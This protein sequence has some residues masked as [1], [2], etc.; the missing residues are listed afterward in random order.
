V[1]GGGRTG[2]PAAAGAHPERWYWSVVAALVAVGIVALAGV[3][4]LAWGIVFVSPLRY[5]DVITAL[6]FENIRTPAGTAV[7]ALYTHL[8]DVVV[9]GF[10]TIGA[11]GLLWTRG[12]RG[13]AIYVLGATSTGALFN[14]ALK[15]IVAR[16][17]PPALWAAVP[18]PHS[19]SFPSGHAVVGVV[20][21]GTLA[22]VAVR[23]LGPG[24]KG[25]VAAAAL[26]V[27][28][29][30]IGFSRLYLGVHWATDVLGGWLLGTAWVALWTAGWLVIARPSPARGHGEG[31]VR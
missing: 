31:R 14:A 24:W 3:A 30:L 5:R 27:V 12:L 23:E 21:F 2:V 11:A 16:T 1:T 26:A 9:A 8:G 22:V 13:D 17:R 7:F 20:L 28:G 10:V 6:T 18:L 15:E 25:I 4:D 19:A 29:V